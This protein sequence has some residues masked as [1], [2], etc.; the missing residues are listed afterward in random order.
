MRGQHSLRSACLA[1]AQLQIHDEDDTEDDDDGDITSDNEVTRVEVVDGEI[2]IKTSSPR[3]RK[4]RKDLEQILILT[5]LEQELANMFPIV[6]LSVLQ[7]ASN[8][9]EL[10]QRR[11][12]VAAE[13]LRRGAK[14]SEDHFKTERFAKLAEKI[15]SVFDLSRKICYEMATS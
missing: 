12:N 7:S 15:I 3:S 14:Y 4:S 11:C 5:N 13:V 6:R 9:E 2:V 1:M 8:R 10:Y